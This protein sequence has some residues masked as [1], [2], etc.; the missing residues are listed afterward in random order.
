MR[1]KGLRDIK[2]STRRPARAVTFDIR[3]ISSL[4]A[5]QQRT[6]R[7]EET[8]HTPK[9]WVFINEPK[10]SRLHKSMLIDRYQSPNTEIFTEAESVIL[11]V[12]C[13]GLV[14]EQDIHLSVEGDILIFE[15]IGG[16]DGIKRKYATEIVLPF[17]IDPSNISAT[18][19]NG[20]VEACLHP[21]KGNRHG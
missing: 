13:P 14:S 11:I 5:V 2:T 17:L 6:R 9:T 15:A 18:L 3:K 4:A 8:C 10:F 20:I 21:L 19:K 12:D 16:M 1:L 7:E